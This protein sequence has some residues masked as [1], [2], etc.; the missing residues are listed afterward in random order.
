MNPTTTGTIAQQT[1]AALMGP[2]FTTGST[3]SMAMK[4]GPFIGIAASPFALIAVAVWQLSVLASDP[5]L[6]G[7]Y[8]SGEPESG[9]FDTNQ[10]KPALSW[11]AK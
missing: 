7:H 2:I 1:E 10:V 6:G 9:P 3:G 5:R 4:D 8:A 11:S